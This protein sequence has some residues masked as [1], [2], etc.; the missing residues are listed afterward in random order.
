MKKRTSHNKRKITIPE[1]NEDLA[2]D[3]GHHIGDGHM[4]EHTNKGKTRYPFIYSGDSTFDLNYFKTVLLPRK[5]RLYGITKDNLQIYGTELK[6]AFYSVEL[7]EFYTSIGV[8]GGKKTNIAIPPFIMNGSKEMKCA[9]LRG[10]ADS[11]GSLSFKRRHKKIQYYPV[12]GFVMKSTRL[13]EGVCTLLEELGV[14][15]TGWPRKQFDTRTNRHYSS[16]GIDVNGKKNLARW[17]ELIGFNNKRHLDRYEFWT[18]HGYYTSGLEGIRTPA[19][20]HVKQTS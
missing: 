14:T 3:I 15:F 18:E 16:W 12:V 8:E 17:M 13:Y 7:Y 2:E 20:L 11:D 19:L 6:F 1:L 9:F 4:A 10:L 5:R